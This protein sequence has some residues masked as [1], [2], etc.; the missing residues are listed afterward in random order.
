MQKVQVFE[1]QKDKGAI[2]NFELF[3]KKSRPQKCYWG[4]VISLILVPADLNLFLFTFA[5][6]SCFWSV[7]GRGMRLVVMGHSFFRNR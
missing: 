5:I 3:A 4:L 1:K 7:M 2:F 6:G